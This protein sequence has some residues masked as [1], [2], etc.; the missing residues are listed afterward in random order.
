M[1]FTTMTYNLEMLKEEFMLGKSV[2]L[3][4]L[5]VVINPFLIVSFQNCSGPTSGWL[6]S[7]EK[8]VL[9]TGLNTEIK[10]PN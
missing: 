5:F 8:P 2:R 6:A 4:T 9:K 7:N 3:F 10:S 1:F